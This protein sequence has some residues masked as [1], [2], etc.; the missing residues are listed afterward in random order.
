MNIPL[1]HQFVV[2]AQ[3]LPDASVFV[4]PGLF[5]DGSSVRAV[6][7]TTLPIVANESL[8]RRID[9]VVLDRTSGLVSILQGLPGPAPL[10]SGQIALARVVVE[11]VAGIIL[12][13]DIV[14]ERVLWPAS[15]DVV[16][17]LPPSVLIRRVAAGIGMEA[18]FAGDTLGRLS[19]ATT[20]LTYGDGFLED[21]TS[22]TVKAAGI[23]QVTCALG[24]GVE[25]PSRVRINTRL[26]TTETC[27]AFSNAFTNRPKTTAV[28][29]VSDILALQAGEKILVYGQRD[30]V[31]VRQPPEYGGAD[32]SFVTIQR[33]G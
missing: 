3:L 6:G 14:D 9:R 29:I 18:A 20:G 11:P 15:G 27:R 16:P 12:D 1:Q 30:D 10:P 13:A 19:F 31:Q 24:V 28:A 23:Y 17:S 32:M 26:G 5:A 2:R 7:P 22:F 4:E 21:G 33:I 25:V 8:T